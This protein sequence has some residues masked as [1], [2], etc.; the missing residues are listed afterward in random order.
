M[1]LSLR[2]RLFLS[3]G[4]LLTAAL[5]VIALALLLFLTAQPLAPAPTYDRLATIGRELFEGLSAQTNRLQRFVPGQFADRLS[6][7]AAEQ[8]VRVLVLDFARRKVWYDSAG[9][10]ETGAD[11][12]VDEQAYTLPRYLQ[13]ALPAR[14]ESVFGSFA[15]P[16]G[17]PW[18]FAGLVTVRQGAERAA[19]VLADR[20]AHPTLREAIARFRAELALPFCQAALLGLAAAALLAAWISRTI[21]RPLRELGWAAEAVAE[22]QYNQRIQASGPPE[23]R[24]AAAAFNRMSAQVQAAQ[25]AQQDFVANISHDL[26]TPLTSIQGFSQAIIDGTAK[27][28]ARAAAVIHEEA[29][30]L[31]RMVIELTDLA[32]LQ[33]GRMSMQVAP[34]DLGALAGA[35]AERLSVVAQKKGVALHIETPAQPPIAG[36]GDRLARVVTNLVSNAINYT[37]AGGQIWVT[38]RLRGGGVELEVRD[39]GIGIP[40]EELPR[41]FERFYQVDK[42]RGPR[43]GTGLGLAIVHEIVSAHGGRVTAASAGVNQGTTFTVW[44]P[45]PEMSTIARRRG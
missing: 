6:A 32:R 5:V 25:Q 11:F 20:A 44:L 37:P 13:R 45:T 42:A 35:V 14:T 15:D 16:D 4:L 1:S 43:R 2:A 9:V 12:P 10:F 31:N 39:T 21:A 3:Y 27:D 18:L 41:I 24:A 29:G 23:V 33:A 22:G 26:K 30:R 8:E 40:P 28:P 36:D 19:L 38:T 7:F 17:T 34:V